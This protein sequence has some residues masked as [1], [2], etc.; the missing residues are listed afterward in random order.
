MKK[1]LNISIV[2]LV[3]LL[4]TI[5][6][7]SCEDENDYDFKSKVTPKVWGINGLSEFVI[8]KTLTHDYQIESP[9][10]GSTYTWS[11]VEGGD[12][13]SI[14]A[15]EI[16]YDATVTIIG[17]SSDSASFAISVFETTAGGLVS[18]PETLAIQGLPYCLLEMSQFEGDYEELADDG[19]LNYADVTIAQDPDDLFF[20]LIITN[21]G[22]SSDWWCGHE[23]ATLEIKLNN[24]DQSVNV[25]EQIVG[26]LGSLCGYGPT[27]VFLDQGIK[28]TFD[29]STKHIEFSLEVTVA[30]GSF[31]VCDYTYDPK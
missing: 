24:C 6:F 2:F 31:G 19:H 15:G 7:N 8:V 16:S 17:E 1:I 14:T 29:E 9:R 25:E 5:G 3:G 12:I 27:T 26:N 20:G 4:V 23:D 10:G 18:E 30:L 21:F 22:F 13:I 28:G 11:V